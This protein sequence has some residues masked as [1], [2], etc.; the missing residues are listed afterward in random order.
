MLRSF[1]VETQRRIAELQAAQL[2]E[3][4]RREALRGE[5][6]RRVV[7]AQEAERQRIAR[8]LHDATGQSLTAIGLGLSSVLSSFQ[9]HEPEQVEHAR[10]R[11]AG[12]EFQ[13]VG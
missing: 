5:L 4:H 9:R 2:E 3:A 8:E 6:L 13:D 12:F 1:D 10:A 11:V 7:A